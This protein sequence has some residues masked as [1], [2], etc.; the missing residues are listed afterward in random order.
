MLS[1]VMP[2]WNREK[3]LKASLERY[4]RL[5]PSLH[6]EV[7][8]ANDGSQEPEVGNYSFPVRIKNLPKKDYPLNPC[9]PLNK[10][11]K[12]AKGSVIVITNP[13]IIHK[14]PVFPQMMENLLSLGERGYV[15]AA[16]KGEETKRFHCHSTIR[17]PGQDRIPKGYG[18]HFCGM[19][20]KK[21][22]EEVGGFDED[23]RNGSGYDDNDFAWRVHRAKGNVKVRDDLIVYHPRSGTKWDKGGFQRNKQIFYSKWENY[24]NRL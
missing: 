15:L 22:F 8:I 13:E 5:Y 2:Y 6:M 3:Q 12:N 14:T 4:E 1:L 23:Y 11:V 17:G 7:V 10:A 9:V 16:C 24:W 18:L 20:Y 19:M 21:F